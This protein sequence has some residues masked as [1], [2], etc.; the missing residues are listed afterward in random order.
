[1]VP[2]EHDRHRTHFDD[3]AHERADRLMR[4]FDA[5]RVNC[6]VP[7][8]N[9]SQ[10]LKRLDTDAVVDER[11]R[12]IGQ[13]T[14]IAAQGPRPKRRAAMIDTHVYRRAEH[15]HIYLAGP[16]VVLIET[17]RH[18][19]HRGDPGIRHLELIALQFNWTRF[20]AWVVRSIHRHLP[21]VGPEI[22]EMFPSPLKS[23]PWV[24]MPLGH[25]HEALRTFTIA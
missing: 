1:M 20:A 10:H 4:I 11:R 19:K 7:I 12:R 8:V 13:G 6:R 23:G 15:G 21:C 2:T 17:Q 5:Q 25:W 9:D 22:H 14:L 24:E 18:T 16:Q 3:L